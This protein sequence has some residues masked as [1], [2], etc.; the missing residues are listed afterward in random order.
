MGIKHPENIKHV[1][2][3]TLEETG[4]YYTVCIDVVT[5]GGITKV[6]RIPHADADRLR[7]LLIDCVEGMDEQR[8]KSS[9]LASLRRK[10]S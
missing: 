7:V 5:V 3:V 9:F 6:L 2:D 4:D 8:R 10:R 1:A